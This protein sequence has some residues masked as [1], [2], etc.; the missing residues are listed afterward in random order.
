MK[1]PS[2]ISGSSRLGLSGALL[3]AALLLPSGVR[4]NGTAY[5][6]DVNGT[7]AGFG[8]PSGAYN[9]NGT[10]WSKD[11]TGV[12]APGTLATG[13]QLTFGYSPSDF[14]GSTFSINMTGPA[15]L[16][17]VVNSTNANITLTGTA[18]AYINYASVT[19]TVAGGSTLTEAVTFNGYGLNFN[20]DAV[21][22]NGAGTLNFG[23]SVGY[24]ST[25]S[26]NE[27]MP[28][29]TVNFTSAWNAGTAN[30][31][32]YVLTAGTLNFSNAA[33]ANALNGLHAGKLFAL[34]GGVL[35]NTSGS[36]LT[37]ALGSGSY[38]IGG[39]FTFNGSSSLNLGPAAVALGT[40]AQVTV[41]ANTL[42]VGGAVSGAGGL[43]LAGAGTLKLAGAG[44]FNGGA[45]VNAGTL[46]L[47]NSLAI[48]N[49]VLNLNGG[50]VVFDSAVAANA[51][52]AAGLAASASGPGFDLALQNNA[53][54]PAPVALTLLTATTSEYSGVLSGPG[55]L[56]IRG[57]G[58]EDLAGA[59]TYIGNTTVTGGTLDLASTNA[60]QDS[61]VIMNGGALTFDSVAGGTA[62]WLGGLAAVTN[63][64]G[65][66]LN[67]QNTANSAITLIVGTN[68]ASTAYAGTLTDAGAGGSL[69][70]IGTGTLTLS[71]NESF[72]G[73]TTIN[74]G[75][76][77]GVVGGGLL[78]SAVTVAALPGNSANL[79]VL[80][81]GGDAQWSCPS[82]TINNGGV[83]S[84]LQFSFASGVTPSLLNAPLNVSG[85]V[86]FLTSVSVSV[87]AAS[88][89]ATTGNGYPLLTWGSGSAPSLAGITL[90]LPSRV[91]G[92]L[93]IQGSTLYLQVTGSTEPASWTGGNGTW[94]L[95]DS[96]NLIWKD[97]TG[98]STYYQ[99]GIVGDSVVFDNTLGSG[100]TVTLNVSV[101]PVNVAVNNPSASYTIT[102]N[103][104]ITG[105]TPLIKTGAGTL[106]LATTNTYSGGT[107]LSSGQLN[108]NNGGSSAA[109]SAIGTGPLVIAGPAVIDNTG[110]ADVVLKPVIRETWNAD[111]TYAGSLHS[112]NLGSGAVTLA[113]N[114]QV[115]VSANTLTV[116]GVISDAGQ[117][118]SLT[119]TGAG[120]LTLSGENSYSGGTIIN[121][122][123]V[124][125]TTSASL[126][127]SGNT[128]VNG[129]LNLT[130]GAGD[131]P[132]LDASLSGTGIVNFTL[133]TGT[134][135][136]FLNGNNSGFNGT[137]NVGIN[138]APGA[139]KLQM[140]GLLGAGAVVNVLTN[141]TVYV[142][143]V[144]QPAAVTLYG[145]VTGELLG[146]LRL[147][148]S[149]T[150]SGPVTLAG[151][152]TAA[153]A[154]LIGGNS[155]SSIISGN[156]GQTNGSWTLSKAGGAHLYL[157]GTNSYTGGTLVEAGTLTLYNDQS[158][159]TGGL[160]VGADNYNNCTLAVG[161]ASQTLPTLVY[162]PAV[163]WVQAGYIP[164]LGNVNGTGYEQL[165][166]SGADG[167]PA[168]VTN[169]GTLFAGRNS[170][171]VIGSDAIWT[172]S[173]TIDLQPFGGYAA[174]L[175]VNNGGTLVYTGTNGVLLTELPGTSA[176]TS[177][178]IGNAA[179][180][181]GAFITGQPFYFNSNSTTATG[182]GIITLAGGGTV[183]LATNIPQLVA[184]DYSG[185]VQ[186]GNGGGVIDTEGFST[187][188][189][190]GITNAPGGSGS[191]IKMGSGTLA[192][193]GTNT[194]FG[195]GTTVSNGTLYITTAFDSPGESFLV[196]DGTTL[197]VINR[198]GLTAQINSLNLGSSS[199][200]TTLVFTNLSSPGVPVVNASGVVTLAGA[201]NVIIAD[202]AHLVAAQEYPLLQY[203]S[204]VTNSGP[205]F[206]LT[207]P[208]GVSGVLTNDPGISA[209]ALIVTGTTS[210]PPTLGSPQI[211]GTN[212]V[213]N[214]SNGTPG[215]SVTVLTTTNL[216]LPLVNWISAT[217]GIFDGA[218]NFHYTVS[219]A[220]GS[221]VPQ[222]YYLLRV[223]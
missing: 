209:L 161:D 199:G 78:N 90:V 85:S 21:T 189:A 171:V 107:T 4:A 160:S 82:L 54:T 195:A 180:V 12:T 140:N 135:A 156:I 203:S 155:G 191:L 18:N 74:A 64:V 2:S 24:N 41:N 80:Y 173:G 70:K 94:D 49:S 59:N 5:Y 222:Q 88:L 63:G 46:D 36:P 33:S 11:T 152:N 212:L 106:T 138:A 32:S 51:F 34:N 8:A 188:I 61:T 201:C 1:K 104:A 29:G 170:S 120:T 35:D 86:N 166:A 202:A 13:G 83:S 142:T 148:A 121:A 62:F 28:G 73:P 181:G 117:A 110:G 57:T 197:G 145:G 124:N 174:A 25:S 114:R 77:Q 119:K 56:V 190:F 7:T 193:T 213:L 196:N 208:A 31:A 67:L 211:S 143:G 205:G 123:T 167:V 53:A 102:G 99:Q 44:T 206:A 3:A 84:G 65:Y 22:L 147:D 164:G 14:N 10:F 92:H 217:N 127:T 133:G 52:T 76:L 214:A 122:G 115:T 220:V 182:L 184:G 96:A 186:L 129:T 168:I 60:V 157:T 118:F 136:N 48:Q 175:S 47:A 125:V 207:L 144:D 98:A 216:A 100:G 132:G 158:S 89:P 79:G 131:Y 178:N 176:A 126:D 183:V 69:V 192:L 20:N 146:Q 163:N 97:N 185:R 42:T 68:N 149:A 111:F 112:L 150:W 17:L 9:E 210:T 151:N 23:S 6:L 95:N 221:S 116:G 153:F 198:S 169:N 66:D 223:P 91:A 87:V 165:I 37:L 137:L 172:Q 130:A 55:S 30:Q 45:T 58:A 162:V 19:W 219:G 26:I 105:S 71:A 187:A 179:T 75:Q 218:G 16:G 141:A 194:Y 103:G 128:T 154:G 43:A 108:L 15:W 200:P 27:N 215:G 40:A 159:A 39:S 72:S 81:T 177:L 139:G 101:V 50:A 109:N 93:V 134:A 38:S 113:A 204:I